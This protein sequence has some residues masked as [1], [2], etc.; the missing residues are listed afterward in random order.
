MAKA[1][2]KLTNEPHFARP[3]TRAEGPGVERWVIVPPLAPDQLER[4]EEMLRAAYAMGHSAAR[5]E[6][7]Q[8]LGIREQ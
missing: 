3:I 7:Q 4:I 8:V 5:Y 2:Y 1:K 6:I